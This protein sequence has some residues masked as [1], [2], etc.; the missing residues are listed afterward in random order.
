MCDDIAIFRIW[1]HDMRNDSG[2]YSVSPGLHLLENRALERS[3]LQAHTWGTSRQQSLLRNLQ[4]TPLAL[5]LTLP[6]HKMAMP[7]P[8]HTL[9]ICCNFSFAVQLSIVR[10]FL[11]CSTF[12]LDVPLCWC[13]KLM[14]SRTT[15][16]YT[17]PT[18]TPP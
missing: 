4:K 5:F 18:W 9:L 16:L 6:T 12:A 10:S 3:C 8:S 11:P 13:M 15:P 7:T 2:L 1:D 17:N 14:G